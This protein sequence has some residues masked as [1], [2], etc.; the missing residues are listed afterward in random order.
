MPHTRL[1]RVNLGLVTTVCHTYVIYWPSPIYAHK[2]TY[3]M[4]LNYRRR[5][6]ARRAI[7]L[8][9]LHGEFCC[10]EKA[11]TRALSTAY[12]R[13]TYAHDDN[14][15]DDA[16]RRA[17]EERFAG[18]DVMTCATSSRGDVKFFHF[19]LKTLHTRCNVVGCGECVVRA[20]FF[21]SL[22]SRSPAARVIVC[23]PP[24]IFVYAVPS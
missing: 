21:R 5:P 10:G 12:R 15:D 3:Q 17:R 22:A 16:R 7:C 4:L 11:K 19:H 8:L 20:S 6:A 2:Q 13:P 9:V 18:R 23:E 1:K 14:I 24:H